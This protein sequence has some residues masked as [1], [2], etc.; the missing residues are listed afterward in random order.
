MV[1]YVR[2]RQRQRGMVDPD[3]ES[4]VHP[5][6]R[7]EVNEEK[8]SFESAHHDWQ[9]ASCRLDLPWRGPYAGAC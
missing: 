1:T 8:N 6:K 5:G 9:L 7:I 2:A 3:F 4:L